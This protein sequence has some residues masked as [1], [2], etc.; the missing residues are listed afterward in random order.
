MPY[1]VAIAQTSPHLGR[2]AENVQEALA[3]AREAHSRGAELCIFPELSLTGYDLKDLVPEV[4]LRPKDTLFQALLDESEQISLALGLVERSEEDL[5]F[6]S[7]YLLDRGEIVAHHRKVY[8]ATYGMFDEERYFSRGRELRAWPTRFGR[9]GLLICEDVWHPSTVHIVVQDGAQAIFVLAAS[10][11]RGLPAGVEESEA[12]IIWQDM[13]RFYARMYGSYV[14]YANR[15]G[16]ED[17]VTFFG[18]ST[19]VDPWGRT[20]TQGSRFGPELLLATID[21]GEV[22]RSRLALPLIGDEDLHMT[23][24]ELE[25]IVDGRP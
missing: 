4:A 2:L 10:P 19:V 20:I 24:R 12:T 21:D 25:R 15:V 11:T 22:R 18:S 13:V 16:C 6:N 5:Y 14:I 1:T 17:G 8:L 23:I 7:A 3:L 9:I